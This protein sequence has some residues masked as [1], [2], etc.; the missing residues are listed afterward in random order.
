MAFVPKYHEV[1]IAQ[2]TH[3]DEEK[4]GQNWGWLKKNIKKVSLVVKPNFFSFSDPLLN[5]IIS[6]FIGSTLL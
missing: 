5:L 3:E 6:N 4:N 2:F 1:I